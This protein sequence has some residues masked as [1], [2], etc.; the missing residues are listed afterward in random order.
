[1][2]LTGVRG[3][4]IFHVGEWYISA[5][6]PRAALGGQMPCLC[7]KLLGVVL[8]EITDMGA[9]NPQKS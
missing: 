8:T 5:E 7:T 1:M 6:D 4:I 9:Q 3:I 2:P